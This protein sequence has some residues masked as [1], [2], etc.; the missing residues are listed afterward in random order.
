L[1]RIK[2]VV[3]LLEGKAPLKTAEEWDNCGLLCGDFNNKAEKIL[4]SLDITCEVIDEAVQKGVDLI[5]SHHPLI[6]KPVKSVNTSTIQG[7]KLIKLIQNNISAL[8]IHTPLDIAKEGVND[9]LAARLGLRDVKPLSNSYTVSYQKLTVFVPVGYAER[10]KSAVFEAGG[11]E[12][13]KYRG[14]AFSVK[15]EGCF[16]PMDN[17]NPFI[18]KKGV[19]ERVEEIRLEFIV[20]KDNASKV[21]SEMLAAHPYETPAYYLE[22]TYAPQQQLSL[23]RIGNLSREMSRDEFLTFVCA[24]LECKGLRYCGDRKSIKKVAVSGGGCA[25]LAEE[26]FLKGA[27]AFIT[28]DFKYHDMLDGMEKGMFLI[29]AGHFPTENIILNSL[30]LLLSNAFPETEVEKSEVHADCIRFFGI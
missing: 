1:T 15:G 8:C 18:G 13:E 24:S 27:D 21:I 5:I 16:I 20:K 3:K 11:G 26:A 12:Y 23:G 7:K 19:S 25:H 17:A 22:D 9:A 6:F 10:V 28:G 30:S 4:L 2:D 14:C 29:D